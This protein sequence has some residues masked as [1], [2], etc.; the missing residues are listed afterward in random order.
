MCISILS[1]LAPDLAPCH[2]TTPSEHLQQALQILARYTGDWARCIPF[3]RG[4]ANLPPAEAAF[5]SARWCAENAPPPEA[6]FCSA[7][8]RFF[9][10]FIKQTMKFDRKYEYI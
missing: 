3:A 10:K 8:D 5:C 4:I 1:L 9:L 7:R 2:F 6:L